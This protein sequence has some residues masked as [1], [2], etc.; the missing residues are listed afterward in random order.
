MKNKKNIERLFKES[1]K[2]FEVN[3]SDSVWESL[4]NKLI[5]KQQ[6]KKPF[7]IWYKY[8]GVAA[9]L[10]LF[11]VIGK[12][13]LNTENSVNSNTIVDTEN[14]N[15][16]INSSKPQNNTAIFSESN[17]TNTTI[18]SETSTEKTSESNSTKLDELGDDITQSNYSTK[19]NNSIVGNKTGN[20][21]S[22]KNNSIVSSSNLNEENNT[23]PTINSKG[24]AFNRN[25]STNDSNTLNSNTQ[26]QVTVASNKNSKKTTAVNSSNRTNEVFNPANKQSNL[27]VATTQNNSEKNTLK[28]K[29]QKISTADAELIN[30][31]IKNDSFLLANAIAKTEDSIEKEKE[32][33][34]WQV[35]ANIAPVYYNTMGKGSHIHEQFNNNDKNGEVNTSYGVNVGYAINDKL[36]IRTG[37]STLNLSYDTANVILFENISGSNSSVNEYRNISFAPS[38]SDSLNII[39]STSLQIQQVSPFSGSSLDTS[40]SQQI[41]YLE[42]PVEIQYNLIERKFNL[43]LIGGFSTFFLNDNEIYTEIDNRRNYI[44][45]ANNINDVSF[46]TNFGIGLGYNFSDSFQ[47]NFEPTFK[48]QLNA[49]SDTSGNFRPYI[50]GVYT[51]LSYKF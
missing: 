50:I 7:S 40:I 25:K 30:A 34:R 48:Y 23:N 28:I 35:Y 10:L 36:T 29:E 3:P 49:F 17:N 1:F 16:P 4:Q 32:V 12:S 43:Q 39:S 33:N 15:S 5:D 51:G 31:I 9:L 46:S 20:E 27:S 41:S 6:E 42:V 47:F 11:F 24:N 2:N 18:V 22:A 19:N 8:A 13:L 44:G 37:I 14:S 26:P 38:V 45:K 21:E